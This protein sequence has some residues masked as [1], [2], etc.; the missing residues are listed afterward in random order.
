MK[1]HFL[2]TAVLVEMER[3]EQALEGVFDQ[4]PEDWREIY[5]ST[6]RQISLCITEMVALAQDELAMSSVDNRSLQEAASSFSARVKQHQQDWPLDIID[7]DDPHC[8]KSFW[9]IRNASTA[10]KALMYAIIDRYLVDDDHE[11]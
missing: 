8:K 6:R 1:K 7:P 9:E 11:T 5:A 10:F 3:L 4:P 2:L